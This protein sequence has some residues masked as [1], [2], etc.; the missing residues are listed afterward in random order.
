MFF[1]TVY[2][3]RPS[4]TVTKYT[5]YPLSYWWKDYSNGLRGFFATLSYG[6]QNLSGKC[7]AFYFVRQNIRSSSFLAILFFYP[8]LPTPRFKKLLFGGS[9]IKNPKYL[10]TYVFGRLFFDSPVN[11]SA[12]TYQLFIPHFFNFVIT[13]IVLPKKKER[14][15]QLLN[16]SA[17]DN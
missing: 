16:K 9:Y 7:F 10:K 13:P 5:K 15:S 1:D 2:P 8:V 11:Y 6:Q 3:A 4:D 14:I 12:D 17:S